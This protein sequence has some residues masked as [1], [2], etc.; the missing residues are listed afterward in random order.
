M[1]A[2]P[3]APKKPSLKTQ[4]NQFLKQNPNVDLLKV[5][6]KSPYQ[7][8]AFVWGTSKPSS[9]LPYLQSIQRVIRF[10]PISSVYLTESQAINLAATLVS[11]GIDSIFKVTQLSLPQFNAKYGKLFPSK[12]GKRLVDQTYLNATHQ[13]TRLNLVSTDLQQTGQP[14]TLAASI[15]KAPPG[16]RV[17]I[18]Y[19]ALFGKS[20]HCLCDSGQSVLSAPA[21]FVDLMQLI[22]TQIGEP[23]EAHLQLSF[24]RPDLTTIPLDS[25]NTFTEVLYLDLV[26]QV[27]DQLIQTQAKQNSSEAAMLEATYPFCMPFDAYLAKCQLY[28]NQKSVDLYQLC[29]TTMLSPSLED[30]A[31]AFLQ[32]GPVEEAL[33]TQPSTT[34]AQINR[35]FGLDATA[36][37]I[38]VLSKVDAF[39]SSTQLTRPQLKELLQGNLN[40]QELEAGAASTFFIN[41]VTGTN[42][43]F[44]REKEGMLELMPSTANATPQPLKLENLDRLNRFIRLAQLL[45]WS[46]SDLNWVLSSSFNS[47]LDTNVLNLLASIKAIQQRTK[48]PLDVLCSFWSPLKTQGWGTSLHNI[49]EMPDLFDHVFNNAL[50]NEYKTYVPHNP[51]KLNAELKKLYIQ[52][53]VLPL[54]ILKT[55]PSWKQRL[56]PALGVSE[57]DLNLILETVTQ[58]KLWNPGGK[59][60]TYNLKNLS[61]L[62]RFCKLPA[63]LQISVPDFM[64]LLDLLVLDL[65]QV[66]LFPFDTFNPMPAAPVNGYQSLTI[67]TVAQVL[68]LIELLLS[69]TQ[70]LREI[71][72]STPQLRYLCIGGRPDSVN[73]HAL[74]NRLR[75]IKRQINDALVTPSY[76]ANRLAIDEASA[77]QIMQK[78]VTAKAISPQGVVLKRDS[79][80]VTDGS[81]ALTNSETSWFP[82]SLPWPGSTGYALFF[83]GISAN[84][85]CGNP[86]SLQ[87]TGAIT[88]ECWFRTSAKLGNYKTLVSKWYSAGVE[89]TFTLGW[90][91]KGLGFSINDS[92]LKAAVVISPK[93]YNDG[94]WHHAAGIWDGKS[95]LSLYVD[96]VLAASQTVNNFSKLETDSL[97]LL[98]GTDSRYGYPQNDRLFEG[99]ICNV[100]IWKVARTVAQIQASLKIPDTPRSISADRLQG[101]VG[102][103]S[104]LADPTVEDAYIRQSTLVDLPL[105]SLFGI[106]ASLFR[107]IAVPAY[108]GATLSSHGTVSIFTGFVLTTL[109]NTSNLEDV[110][111]NEYLIS[112]LNFIQQYDDL[113]STLGLAP[114]DAEVL[115]PIFRQSPS[116]PFSR[117][118][119]HSVRV[120]YQLKK[121]SE[122]Y[123]KP[124]QKLATFFTHPLEEAMA[125]L[126]QIT[127]WTLDEIK[128]V[129]PFPPKEVG[130]R[131]VLIKTQI[132]M[133]AQ[134]RFDLA[135]AFGTQ[136]TV[137]IHQ[138]TNRLW[139]QATFLKTKDAAQQLYGLLKANKEPL[140][141]QSLNQLGREERVH[142]AIFL[143]SQLPGLSWIKTSRDLYDFLLID[144]E[145]GKTM[146]T[147]RVKEA[148]SALQIYI[149]RCRLNLELGIVWNAELEKWWRWMGTYQTWRAN[150][151][152]FLYP[153]NYILPQLRKN[154]SKLF[155][156]LQETL[157]QS[158]ITN[159]VVEEAFKT[160][161][162]GFAEVANLNIVGAYVYNEKDRQ[163]SD[164]ILVLFGQTKIHPVT[165]YYRTARIVPN[166]ESQP[167]TF[168]WEAWE[169][170]NLTIHSDQVALAFAFG[171]LFIFWAEI[172][173]Q[174]I[175]SVA[176]GPIM[177]TQF[178]S[179]NSVHI[180]HYYSFYDFN[181]KWVHPQEFL[182]TAPIGSDAPQTV[183][184]VFDAN[185]GNGVGLLYILYGKTKT[186]DQYQTVYTLD[187][188]LEATLLQ[189]PWLLDVDYIRDDL[190]IIYAKDTWITSHMKYWKARGLLEEYYPLD[191]KL[192]GEINS[193]NTLTLH[194]NAHYR[195]RFF[196]SG[197]VLYLDKN[198]SLDLTNQNLIGKGISF[199]FK[200][201]Q[202]QQEPICLFF[203]MQKGMQKLST[204]YYQNGQLV[205]DYVNW[206]W[207]NSSVPVSKGV[208]NQLIISISNYYGTGN[209]KD[210]W[211]IC[212]LNGKLMHTPIFTSATYSTFMQQIG[213]ATIGKPK[214]SPTWTL[215]G[216]ATIPHYYNDFEISDLVVYS[217]SIIFNN[218]FKMLYDQQLDQDTEVLKTTKSTFSFASVQNQPDWLIGKSK[219]GSFLIK[220]NNN[221]LPLSTNLDV[222]SA[223][224][225][226]R[227]HVA[228]YYSIRYKG[229]P[230]FELVGLT[231]NSTSSLSKTLFVE[232]IDGLL[233][234]SSQRTQAAPTFVPQSSKVSADIIYNTHAV[235]SAP[236]SNAL[237]FY[238]ADGVYYWEIYFYAPFLIA[239]SL[240]RARL[241]NQTAFQVQKWFHYIFDPTLNQGN[242]AESDLYHLSYDNRA[243]PEGLWKELQTQ[244]YLNASGDIQP[245]F[246][247]L[248]PN[249]ILNLKA[250]YDQYNFEVYTILAEHQYLFRCWNFLP[251]KRKYMGVGETF[252]LHAQEQSRNILP[253][254]GVGTWEAKT[255]FQ[256][257]PDHWAYSFHMNGNE[258]LTIGNLQ[259]ISQGF[260]IE[261]WVLFEMMDNLIMLT[262]GPNFG[263]GLDKN[264][265]H[266]LFFT[267]VESAKTSLSLFTQSTNVVGLQW[268]HVC[269]TWN[270]TTQMF[271]LYVNGKPDPAG[272]KK[273]KPDFQQMGPF[274][275]EGFRSASNT[276]G[277][278]AEIRVW[279][280]EK[281]QQE[282]QDLMNTCLIH[283]GLE[284]AV[285][286]GLIR[287]LPLNKGGGDWI[288]DIQPTLTPLGP[289]T[290]Y[291]AEL[292]LYKNDPFDPQ[293][294]AQ[295]RPLAFKKTIFMNYINSLIDW[296]NTLYQQDTRETIH[297]ATLLYI[298]AYNLLGDKPAESPPCSSSSAQTYQQL[299]QNTAIQSFLVE[300]ENAPASGSV[301]QG[302]LPAD[303]N[304]ML[305][306]SYFCFP[307]NDHLVAYWH[308]IQKNLFNI[309]HNLNIDGKPQHLPLFQPPLNPLAL[310]EATAAGEGLDSAVADLS[311]PVPYY[312]FAVLVEKSKEILSSLEQLEMSLLSA[313][314]KKDAADFALLKERQEQQIFDM[315][316]ALKTEQIKENHATY[317]ALEISLEN[318]KSRLKYY[319]QL[320][321]T[322][323]N[324]FEESQMDALKTAKKFSRGAQVAQVAA[325]VASL[326]PQ[327]GS[328]LSLNYGGSQLGA[329]ANAAAGA[330]QIEGSL[331]SLDSSLSGLKGEHHRREKNWELQL[332]LTTRDIEQINAQIQGAKSRLTLSE[333]EL[334][335]LQKQIEQASSITSFL[336][337]KFTNKELYEWMIGRLQSLYY[338]TFQMAHQWAQ[339]A[340][341]AMQF[342]LNVEEPYLG[343]GYW[344][345]SKKGLLAAESLRV[346]LQRMEKAYLDQNQR[347]FEIEKTVSLLEHQPLSVVNLKSTKKCV[348]D[349][350]ELMFDL[351]FPGHYGRQI[352][353]ISLSFP[354]VVGPYQ[355]INATLTQTVNRLVEKPDATGAAANYLIDP[356]S[357]K[358]GVPENIRQNW[359]HNQQIALS[360]GMNDAGLFELNFH[361]ARYLPFENTGVVSS[362]LLEMSEFVSPDL[363]RNLTDVIIKLRYTAQEGGDAYR[364]TII[365]LLKKQLMES[366]RYYDLATLFSNEWFQFLNPAPKATNQV[367]SFTT[368]VSLLPALHSLKLTKVYL[369]LAPQDSQTNATLVLSIQD[370]SG[371]NL[372]TTNPTFSLSGSQGTSLKIQ[373]VTGA[374][375]E[376]AVWT[377]TSQGT[378]LNANN[379][380]NIGLLATF[381][382]KL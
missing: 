74:M 226:I 93:M 166:E 164:K 163:D 328:P 197:K 51:Q 291:K 217:Q 210:H 223:K 257:I 63:V 194:G 234:L 122:R 258:R 329:A 41:A 306:N 158:N 322:P 114:A 25:E 182:E 336:K 49:F 137:L 188:R 138:V 354:T 76:L 242:V 251:F 244:G 208:W 191:N 179:T 375:F 200:I 43:P 315:N 248:P 297:E 180:K 358:S 333:K 97:N 266:A 59:N 301:N 1:A 12:L 112:T 60:F 359:G 345:G 332:A 280:R 34:P 56:I 66:N 294:I 87:I 279:N 123:S 273:G 262:S 286:Q 27:L 44:L 38:Q 117:F 89:G 115:F 82:A 155:A 186:K 57:T 340:Q 312:R 78:L 64:I 283:I 249:E 141:Q 334:Q 299:E 308:T 193:K 7:I 275:L 360:Q 10:L 272:G 167:A 195:P 110:L 154:K 313:L 341:K 259:G 344:N 171:K 109:L 372:L 101:L 351:D 243:T 348:F 24:R 331:H 79:F 264:Q 370:R 261:C 177:S 67:G 72:L 23:S 310:V 293:R 349:L 238:G 339:L 69:I 3:A 382:G 227:T 222:L 30:V 116:V 355:N 29:T 113:I 9:F 83:D 302:S 260:T 18:S 84:I 330:I 178:S 229:N 98:I 143:L 236:E 131:G 347:R 214:L 168:L 252:A 68:L 305:V 21:Y 192:T 256:N 103:W 22:E 47:Q 181:K 170:V 5:N 269:V 378:G 218:T 118:S 274:S 104:L 373:S 241:D 4:L 285:S 176:P 253:L 381:T 46:F 183:Q 353:S 160:Y 145:M 304:Q 265:K 175:G 216:G 144:V 365:G 377:L 361:D 165:S 324:A 245:D 153:E 362:W 95:L 343:S 319:Q 255:P 240:S 290:H 146:K 37:P 364:K 220:P 17:P 371:N 338:Q 99:F 335:L 284:Q 96:G 300:L 204:F 356:K 211:F 270:A 267:V 94:M 13:V 271:L 108:S 185:A 250:P 320:M 90:S 133:Q 207:A 91:T 136:P 124:H 150:R 201:P 65:R 318:A 111:Q 36:N 327:L 326:I 230:H 71:N 11:K 53:D 132:L 121:L 134:E 254:N 54:K 309:R 190:P 289:P 232:G 106:E 14:H 130:L 142:Y 139:P 213:L 151:E 307:E 15:L 75:T 196:P 233:S 125:Q 346:D 173:K 237:D 277:N 92:L 61:I 85:N 70:W 157:L 380:H 156:E 287:Y 268:Y 128:V 40:G 321:H 105:A 19:E 2:P 126:P 316:Q 367:L 88:V 35:V 225:S 246:V 350:T 288:W 281:T 39:L 198:S 323:L 77:T 209:P 379:L 202:S 62:Y 107:A 203:L 162:D 20:F 369:Q 152:V 55:D 206:G 81:D 368:P 119:I 48:L 205:F 247:Q 311:S 147:S 357:H 212:A 73:S 189:K 239:N 276:S 169:K 80:S 33:L 50:A 8:K 45:G 219:A 86:S 58:K 282:I 172:T 228:D 374:S 140:P 120:L 199:W 376:N 159:E 292:E 342:E 148:I 303:P 263:S 278:Y 6:L 31:K 100:K 52:H 135:Q 161:L 32:I 184:A 224:Q 363:M 28:L 366:E 26:R 16:G 325:G 296:A 314:E 337:S 102:Y 149:N 187:N 231:S 127:G 298:T 295:L 129:A 352:K 221:L 317:L 174:Q 42:D 215:Q 235:D